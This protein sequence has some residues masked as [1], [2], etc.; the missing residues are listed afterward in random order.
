MAVLKNL[1]IVF[2]NR[3][4]EQKAAE[5]IRSHARQRDWTPSFPIPL[6]R[7]I[8]H[9]LDLCIDFDTI[10]E[11]PGTTIWGCIEPARRLITLNDK[12]ADAFAKCPG[13]ERF[14][15]GHEVGHWVMHVDHSGL[16]QA[17]LFE[18]EPDV[19]VCRDGDAST[20]ERVADRFSA[21]LLMPRDLMLQELPNYDVTTRERFRALAEKINV[22]N[23]ALDLRLNSMGVGHDA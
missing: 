22:S 9:T 11:P 16:S 12:H 8:E 6:D 1:D 2:S 17:T 20:H 19:I 5:L 21:F 7:L 14:T 10:D 15:L 4:L 3:V 13:L 23:R 18:P